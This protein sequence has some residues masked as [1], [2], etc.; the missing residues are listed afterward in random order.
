M[1]FIDIQ[2]DFTK[3]IGKINPRQHS[4]NF[5]PQLAN[6][7]I[8]GMS[9]MYKR[10]NFESS[11][12]HDWALWNQGERLID[13]HF[14]FPLMHLDPKDPKNYYFEPTDEMIKDCQE[15]GS[16]VYYRM[17]TSIEHSG[18][19]HFNTLPIGD[20]E[21]YAE[22]LAG[23]IRHYTQGWANGFKYDMQYWE[24][25]NEPDCGPV[26]WNESLDDFIKFFVIVLKRLK[27]EFPKLK[28]GG[29]AM[30]WLHKEFFKKLLAACKEAKVTPD[31]I[32]WHCYTNDA[33]NLINQPVDA[34]KFLDELGY[35]KTEIIINEWHF[36]TT[37]WGLHHHVTPQ[38]HQF[39]FD[40]QVGMWSIESAAFNLAVL[41]GWQTTPLDAGFYYGAAPYGTWGFYDQ[42]R[43][44]NKNYF[45]MVM[46]GEIM[47]DYSRI[48][49]STVNDSSLHTLGALSKNG[50]K[51]C[52]L[53]VDYGGINREINVKFKMAK[54][55]KKVQVIVLDQTRDLLPCE[56]L[57]DDNT[58]KLIKGQAGS[59]AFLVK[60]EF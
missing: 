8:T 52:L 18:T 19:R 30:C 40:D 50:K 5:A 29:P 47:A 44:L 42:N 56:F 55:A 14:V 51:G 17:G 22:V 26:M 24:I 11:R 41:A 54:K 1:S 38:R 28:I 49:S 20:Y 15:A 37:W 48:V 25:W 9:A 45:S 23:I 43:D 2:A 39:A 34:R 33:D 60:F 36:L 57:L 46:F 59:A 6:R 12:T 58:I 16:K 10:M 53:V 3:E 7:G 35:K 27:K 13:T 32:S 21:K 31:F 4:S